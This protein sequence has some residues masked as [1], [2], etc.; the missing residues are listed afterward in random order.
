MSDAA[1]DHIITLLFVAVVFLMICAYAG[2]S[3]D[4]Q[5]RC[6]A[7]CGVSQTLTPIMDLQETCLC[8]EGQGKWR[9][10]E[11]SR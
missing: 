11:I 9:R 5:N 6:V 1:I 2:K 8:D 4:F 7:A 3:I 10:Q